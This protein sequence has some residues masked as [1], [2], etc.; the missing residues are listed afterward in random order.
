MSR[1]LATAFVIIPLF[2]AT[3]QGHDTPERLVERTASEFTDVVSQSWS[4]FRVC[5][6]RS[7][8][9]DKRSF[10]RKSFGKALIP[11]SASVHWKELRVGEEGASGSL[12]LGLVAVTLQEQGAAAGVHT[13]LMAAEHPYLKGTKILTRYKPLIRGNTVLILYSETFSN[14][15]V[16]RF[17]E[18]V[19]LPP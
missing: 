17:F 2:L 19:A 15:A 9:D 7:K 3:A 10:L 1:A 6:H 4:N 12:H 5:E 11:A 18:A 13:H 8:T 16:Q 14:E